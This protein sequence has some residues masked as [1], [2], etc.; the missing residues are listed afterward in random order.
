MS[1]NKHPEQTVE[2][3]IDVAS[4]LFLEKGYEKTSI[5]DIV[6]GLG[7]LSKG[8]IY[9]HFASKEDIMLAVYQSLSG[10]VAEKVKKLMARSDLNGAEKLQAVFMSSWNDDEQTS[11]IAATPNL[12]DNPQFLAV[13]LRSTLED[14]I[15][16]YIMPIME[17][18]LR[19]GSIAID[20]PLETAHVFMLLSNIWLNP[21]IV[22]FEGDS[23]ARRLEIFFRIM[24]VLG[25]HLKSDG[26][27]EHM[28]DVLNYHSKLYDSE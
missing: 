15:P 10:R 9:H 19:D 8:A 26:F 25:L 12:L 6:D 14:Y 24:D 1:R 27:E 28:L 22:P 20:F 13:S 18:G 17:E 23:L 11:F 5:Q 4:R 16:N 7:G 3:I 21:L 2:K